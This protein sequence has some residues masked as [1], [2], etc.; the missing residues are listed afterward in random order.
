MARSSDVMDCMFCERIPCE[1]NAK[2]KPA[3]KKREPK[4]AKPPVS[5]ATDATVEPGVE[6]IES[7]GS[8]P[9]PFA[10]MG[11][12]NPTEA[13]ARADAPESEPEKY[14]LELTSGNPAI[15]AVVNSR[16]LSPGDQAKYSTRVLRSRDPR[17]DARL[18]NIKRR[19]ADG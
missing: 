5:A 4:A 6:F 7:K 15:E 14:N 13:L 8:R 2:P 9:S 16:M 11:F 18:G 10:S 3:P 17:L 19:I 1:C 12:V